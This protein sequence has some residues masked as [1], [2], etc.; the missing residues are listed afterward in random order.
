M[1][2]RKV[3]ELAAKLGV[4]LVV[5]K[6]EEYVE[7]TVEAP[8]GQVWSCCRAHELVSTADVDHKDGIADLWIDL[9]DRMSH[10]VEPC[11]DPNCEWC[12]DNEKEADNA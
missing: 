9:A 8:A 10:G 3:F 5:A 6:S 12:E 4:D 11:E 2:K 1:S 7:A